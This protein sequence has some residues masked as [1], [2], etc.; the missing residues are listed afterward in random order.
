VKEAFPSQMGGEEFSVLTGRD[1]RQ[2]Q[3]H[4]E[5]VACPLF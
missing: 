1:S 5:K 2:P 3:K 4:E